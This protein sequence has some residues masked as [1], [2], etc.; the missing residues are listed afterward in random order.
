MLSTP[1]SPPP[2]VDW[3]LP[4]WKIHQTVDLYD[5]GK[6]KWHSSPPLATRTT[7]QKPSA[8]ALQSV[9]AEGPGKST[10]MAV[11]FWF[12]REWVGDKPGKKSP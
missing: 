7:P 3:L 5:I 8:P 11:L 9:V 10:C 6:D 4:K 2:L 12:I 1:S